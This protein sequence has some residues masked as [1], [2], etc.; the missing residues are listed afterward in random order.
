MNPYNLIIVFIVIIISTVL[1]EVA[2]GY[3]AY[4]QG[5]YDGE[6]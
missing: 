6:G 4:F 3:A 5:G 2:H 1:H